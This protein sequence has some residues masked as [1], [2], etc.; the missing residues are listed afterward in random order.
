MRDLA[1]TLIVV[2][3]LPM[4]LSRANLGILMYCWIS[5]MNPHRLSWGFAYN[6]PFAAMISGTTLL[7]MLFSKERKGIPLKPITIV[8]FLWILWMSVTTQFAIEP[9]SAQWEWARS[10]KIQFMTMI[11][12]MLM[13]SRE[14]I[15]ALIWMLVISIGYYGVKGGMFAIATGGAYRV[16]GPPQTFFSGT[17]PLGL[18]L[19]MILPLMLFLFIHSERKVIRYAL[20]ASMLFTSVAVLSTYSRGAFL[21][22]GSVAAYLVLHS[23]HKFKLAPIL[24]VLGV[25][26][27]AFMPEQYTERIQSI[28]NFDQ[29]ESAMGRIRAWQVAYGVAADNP[30]VGGGF[31]MMSA[32]LFERYQPG[33]KPHDMHSIYFEA[34]GEQGFIGLALFLAL[35]FM[36][37]GEGSRIKRLTKGNPDL[38]W[39]Y[40]LA[41]AV[42][43][44]LVAY[45]TGGAFLGLAYFDLYYHLIAV[46]LLIKI[47]VDEQLA[48]IPSPTSR[49]EVSKRTA[50]QQPVAPSAPP[51]PQVARVAKT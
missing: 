33:H 50:R 3:S 49:A 48:T 51:R 36:A 13:Q 18:T 1:I 41:T 12:I 24:L 45:A 23:R 17:N 37:Q 47:V 27:L 22:A 9:E 30:L 7:A 34:L 6:M 38:S 25:G 16:W 21:A 39:A 28:Q 15:I 14:K 29:E 2:A 35:M 46:L 31:Q 19:L 43:T 5:Y 42:K 8:W 4:I 44:S 10:M 40:D 11:T 26:L 32:E 20:L